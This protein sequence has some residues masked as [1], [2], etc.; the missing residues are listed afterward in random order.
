MPL[1]FNLTDQHGI[2]QK[3]DIILDGSEYGVDYYLYRNEDD[4][5]PY[6]WDDTKLYKG[7][8]QCE[9]EATYCAELNFGSVL[10]GGFY[11]VW[12]T[13]NGCW[14]LMNG[15]I[16]IIEQP[17]VAVN[18][19]LNLNPGELMQRINILKNDKLLPGLDRIGKP[20]DG[21]NIVVEYLTE[22]EFGHVYKKAWGEVNTDSIATGWLTY[23]KLPSFYGLDSISY[24]IRNIEVEGRYSE[25][26]VYIMVGNE[27][28][29]DGFSFLL[30]NAFSPNGDGI[31]DKF[32]I[33]GLGELEESKL[34]VF[35]RW[36]TIVFRSK[37][38]HYDND[39]DGR[40]NLTSMIGVGKELP[41]GVYYFVFGVKKN[42][43]GKIVSKE[44][45]GSIE[46]RR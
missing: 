27:P 16:N 13:A 2:V 17:L 18:D 5:A 12:A 39:F 20:E 35:N 45:K 34:E 14:S 1:Q 4:S 11:F 31:N 37:G 30:P 41:S 15:K 7:P 33:M 8:V 22:S 9:V 29:P 6:H 44:Y 42:V 25:A 32:V 24:R 19:T 28:G 38:T 46:L 43:D 10:D 23:K 3:T 26:T 36:G 21:G 40:A